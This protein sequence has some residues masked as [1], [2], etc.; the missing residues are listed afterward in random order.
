MAIKKIWG[1]CTDCRDNGV[2]AEY[3]VTELTV[4][5]KQVLNDDGLG[6]YIKDGKNII[7]LDNE[8]IKYVKEHY[9]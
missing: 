9:Q 3:G 8:Q 2:K 7:C 6:M 1:F 5:Y 4:K